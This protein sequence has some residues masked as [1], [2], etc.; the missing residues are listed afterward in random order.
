MSL[1]LELFIY[2]SVGAGY[3]WLSQN[4]TIFG[5]VPNL[6]FACALCAAIL[7]G[8]VKG[9]AWGFML[10]LYMDLLGSDM[11]GAYALT[12]TVMAYTVHVVRRHFDMDSAFSQLVAALSLSWISMLFYQGLAIVFSRPGNLNLRVFLAE[13]FLN[14]LAVPVLFQVLYGLKRRFGVL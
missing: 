1:V 8:P 4:L 2:L 3:W 9:I 13:P 12:F 7:A 10:G 5:L 11:F 6:L 14:A